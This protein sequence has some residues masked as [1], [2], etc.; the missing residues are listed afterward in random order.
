MKELPYGS[1]TVA[2]ISSPTGYELSE[3]SKNVI[4]SSNGEIIELTFENTKILGKINI[5]KVDHDDESIKLSGAVFE[6][7]NSEGVVVDTITTDENGV[8]ASKELL[9]GSYTVTEVTAPTGYE[10]SEESKNVT[11]KLKWRNIRINI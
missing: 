8:G 5:L 11:I 1:Y 4:I 6:V 9:Y 2:E 10:L 7:K 3:E